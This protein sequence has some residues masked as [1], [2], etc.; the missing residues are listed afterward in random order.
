MTTEPRQRHIVPDE[1]IIVGYFLK[2][3]REALRTGAA[4]GYGGNYVARAY[5]YLT[6]V[7]EREPAGRQALLDAQN[8]FLQMMP[9]PGLLLATEACQLLESYIGNHSDHMDLMRVQH[10]IGSAHMEL[11]MMLKSLHYRTITDAD[12]E[13]VRIEHNLPGSGGGR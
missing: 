5:W 11:A 2:E 3:A 1:I 13:R 8:G 12:L 10:M 7:F 4:G 9:S 6:E